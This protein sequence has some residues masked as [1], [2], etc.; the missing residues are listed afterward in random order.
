[1]WKVIQAAVQGRGHTKMMIPCQDKTYSLF[2]N[3]VSS[4]ALADGAG[5]ARLSHFGAEHISKYISEF[6]SDHFEELFTNDDGA[7]VKIMLDSNIKEQISE[8]SKKLECEPCDLASTL[9]SVSVKDNRYIV[10]HFGDGVIGY[11]RNGEIGTASK[12]ENGEFA[13]TTVFTTS[14]DALS[15]LKLLKGSLNGI[16]GF[17]LMSDGSETSLYDKR[18]N[19][20][21]DAFTRIMRIMKYVPSQKVEE[22][23]MRSLFSV[24]RYATTDDCSIV[25]MT[26][27]DNEFNGYLSLSRNEKMDL[28][29]F[30]SKQKH[31]ATR[32]K[33]CDDIL[34]ALVRPQTVKR[35]AKQV[36]VKQK[37][38]TKYLNRLLELN[39][40]ELCGDSYHTIIT[41]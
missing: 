18:N 38:I 26:N 30:D 25:I 33:H 29:G 15:T 8:L 22:Q 40:I 13:N 34:N 28:L 7:S 41:M 23:L 37:Y 36:H 12:P 4:V 35:L 2:Q 19:K 27:I 21:S 20:P 11:S 1:M 10:L 3:G 9:L 5:S 17:V 6:M 39:Y 24:I 16:D 32:F 31:S 14:S